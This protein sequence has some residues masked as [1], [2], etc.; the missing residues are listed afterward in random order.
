[1][2][3]WLAYLAG[4]G[5]DAADL[6]RRADEIEPFDAKINYHWGLALFQNRRWQ[7]AADRFRKVLLIDPN[8]GGG[9][10][11]LAEALRQQGQPTEAVRYAWRAAR[12]TG[13][14][15]PEALVT[16]ADA[17]SDAGRFPEAAAAATKAIESDRSA[18]GGYRLAFD[19]QRRL[20]EI[21]ARAGH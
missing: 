16:L 19:T 2:L 10:Q 11:G 17:Y 12:L 4:R 3:G 18:T 5:D 20:E 1:M 6:Y 13:F 21:C 7:D 15:D 9:C 8:H 14:Q